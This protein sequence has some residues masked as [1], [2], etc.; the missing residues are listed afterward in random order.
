MAS[1][2]LYHETATDDEIAS[3]CLEPNRVF[4]SGAVYDNH[5]VKLSEKAVVKFGIGVKEEEAN[6][7]RKAYELID[8]NIVCI[9]S[10]YRFFTKGQHGYIVMEYMKGRVLEP[11]EDSLLMNRITYILAYL[12][13]IRSSIPGALGGGVSTGILWSEHSEEPFLHTIQ[14]IESWFNRRLSKQD[15]KLIFSGSELVLCHL[16]IAPRNF[17]LLQ[18]GSICLLDWASAGFYPRVFEE[19]VLRI[20]RALKGSFL[21]DGLRLERLTDE[22]ELQIK[23]MIQAYYNSVRFYFEGER[24][25]EQELEQEK[26]ESSDEDE[27]EGRQEVNGVTPAMTGERVGG[28]SRRAN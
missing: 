22:E 18:D 15:P 5:V 26:D 11:V 17:L 20:T 7:Q 14:E 13:T 23:S 8:K 3:Y 6:S 21:S 10:V 4:L 25:L 28:S 16:D 27:D 2:N 12:A 9:P 24:E 1:L 19:C